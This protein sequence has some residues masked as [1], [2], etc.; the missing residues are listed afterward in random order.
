MDRVFLAVVISG[1]L[2]IVAVTGLLVLYK[3]DRSASPLRQP[4]GIG[5]KAPKQVLSAEPLGLASSVLQPT[6]LPRLPPHLTAAANN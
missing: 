1:L 5:L 3:D 4:A 2:V 6:A